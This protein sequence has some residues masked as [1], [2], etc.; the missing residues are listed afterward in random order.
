MIPHNILGSIFG[1]LANLAL[2]EDNAGGT[3]S[4]QPYYRCRQSYT[5]GSGGNASGV[6]RQPD[7]GAAAKPAVATLGLLNVSLGC[8]CSR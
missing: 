2:L 5:L 1:Q 6:Y 3:Q 4:R 8:P 7:Y